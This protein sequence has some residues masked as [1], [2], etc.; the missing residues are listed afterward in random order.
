MTIADV[1]ADGF[2]SV[3]TITA[4][5]ALV[6]AIAVAFDQMDENSIRRC[7]LLALVTFGRVYDVLVLVHVIQEDFEGKESRFANWKKNTLEQIREKLSSNSQ[8]QTM[9]G[10]KWIRVRLTFFNSI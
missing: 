1:I 8:I 6:E 3:R 5:N 7:L 4:V 9:G 10:T 2:E